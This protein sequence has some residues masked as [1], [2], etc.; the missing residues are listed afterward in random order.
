MIIDKSNTLLR[1]CTT[2]KT[3]ILW[4]KVK[5]FFVFFVV[6]F[7]GFVRLKEQIF[8]TKVKLLDSIIVCLHVLT[9]SVK[10]CNTIP[11]LLLRPDVYVQRNIGIEVNNSEYLFPLNDCVRKHLCLRFLICTFNYVL[12]LICDK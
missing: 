1:H 2:T 4:T 5:N 10:V 8:L 3:D 7:L 6:V 12:V 9:E 11:G